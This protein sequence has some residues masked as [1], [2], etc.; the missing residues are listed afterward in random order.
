[1]KNIFL[2]VDVGNSKDAEVQVI[3]GISQILR[4]L[5]PKR[6]IG[7][8]EYLKSRIESGDYFGEDWEDR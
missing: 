5:S 2:S 3:I 8:L 6:K 1:M 4:S 7:V